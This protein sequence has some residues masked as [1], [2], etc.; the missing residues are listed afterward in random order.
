MRLNVQIR[1]F[2]NGLQRTCCVVEWEP[3]VSLLYYVAISHILLM[4]AIVALMLSAVA[5]SG[6]YRKIIRGWKSKSE[7]VYLRGIKHVRMHS[8]MSLHVVWEPR[9]VLK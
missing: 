5:R 4:L 8:V 6:R 1:L 9:L 7:R 3:H 2:I